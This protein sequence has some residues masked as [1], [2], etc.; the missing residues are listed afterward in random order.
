MQ[1]HEAKKNKKS[2]ITYV[3]PD[4]PV[5]GSGSSYQSK[6]ADLQIKGSQEFFQRLIA[7]L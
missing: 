3:V 7:V 6:L 5:T 1:F 2:V 4:G